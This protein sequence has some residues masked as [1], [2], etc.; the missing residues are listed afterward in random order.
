MK[1]APIYIKCIIDIEGV[2]GSQL[3]ENLQLLTLGI[4]GVGLVSAYV[5][6][7]PEIAARY[8]LFPLLLSVSLISWVICVSKILST[9]GY[10]CLQKL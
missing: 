2:F 4:G 7:T 3:K 10:L 9:C 5:S 8:D 6:Y 1:Y